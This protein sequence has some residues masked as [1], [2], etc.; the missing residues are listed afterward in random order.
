MTVRAGNWNDSWREVLA[1]FKGELNEVPSENRLVGTILAIR[2]SAT[3]SFTGQPVPLGLS[4]GE[5]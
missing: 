5:V 3:G 2:C 4:T 1:N